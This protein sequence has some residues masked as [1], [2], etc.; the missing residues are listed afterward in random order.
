M[1]SWSPITT[2]ARR[3]VPSSFERAQERERQRLERVGHDGDAEL[4][5]DR[6]DPLGEVVR[7][8]DER[9]AAVARGGDPFGDARRELGPAIGAH[10]VVEI[11]DDAAHPARG[12][13][14]EG[15]VGQ[16]VGV[17]VGAEP[18]HAIPGSVHSSLTPLAA[19]P[20]TACLRPSTGVP[21]NLRSVHGG[22]TRYPEHLVSYFAKGYNI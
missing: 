4:R 21:R 15:H 14:V 11:D 16:R 10:G 2:V 7:D 3:G 13:L 20:Q 19:A 5:A 6:G 22:C 9:E 12:E 8:E 18:L 1:K 17:M